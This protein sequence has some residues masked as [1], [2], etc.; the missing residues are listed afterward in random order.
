MPDQR[1]DRQARAGSLILVPDCGHLSQ[2]E[3]PDRLDEMEPLRDGIENP[4][5]TPRK[6]ER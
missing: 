3:H 1:R 4:D 6:E 5:N 2:I